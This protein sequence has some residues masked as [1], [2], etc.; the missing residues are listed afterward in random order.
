MTQESKF[1]KIDRNNLPLFYR[2]ILKMRVPKF[3]N[4]INVPSGI[5]WAILIPVG[6]FFSFFLNIYLLL[7]LS[8]PINIVV[9][10]ILPL[11][12]VLI[13]VRATANRFIDW[14]NSA[15]VGGYVQREIRKV[16]D[17]YIALQHN[18]EQLANRNASD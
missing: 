17:E 11:T 9:V 13:L 3:I 6:I 4:K 5:F 12:M 10:C 15:V 8:F 16:L 18:K 14:W 2:I 7:E 1:K